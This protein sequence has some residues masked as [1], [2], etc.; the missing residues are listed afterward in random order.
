MKQ[1][2]NDSRKTLQGK[3]QQN[4]ILSHQSNEFH[5]WMTIAH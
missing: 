3:W 5:R 2:L 4:F 1:P